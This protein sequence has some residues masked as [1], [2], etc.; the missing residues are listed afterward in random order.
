MAAKAPLVSCLLVLVFAVILELLFSI[1]VSIKTLAP[2]NFG[3]QKKF[4]LYPEDLMR[5]FSQK[6]FA[7]I[8]LAIIFPVLLAA[9]NQPAQHPLDALKTKEYW[10][11][12]DVL[13]DSG[14]MDANTVTHSVLLHEPA[15]DKVLAWKPGDPIFRE[16]DVILLRKGV[17]IEALVDIA[18]HK[19]ESWK[20]RKDVQAPADMGEFRALDEVIKKDPSVIEA[21][22]KHGITDLAPVVCFTDPFSYFALPELEGHRIMMGS[23]SYTHGVYLG[24]SR[25]IEGLQIKVDATEKK[26]LQVIEEGITPVSQAPVNYQDLETAPRPGTTPISIS[27]PLGPSFHIKGSEVSWQNWRFRFRL[28]PRV[29]AVINLAGIQDGDHFRSVLYEGSMSEL[30]VPY[31]DPA[32]GWANRVFIDAGEFYAIGHILKPLRQDIDCP[33][34]AVYFDSLA[35]EEHGFPVIHSQV[36]CLFESYSG[37]PAWRH[38]EGHQLSG[39]GAR[40][41]VLRTA[42]VIGNYDYVLDWRFERDGNLRVAVGATGI[43]ETKAVKAKNASEGG[44][45]HAMSGAPDEFGHFVAENTV[46]VNHDHFFS[47]RLDVDVD[48]VNNSFMAMR[49]VKRQLNNP[50]RKS[51]WVVEPSIAKTEKD[52]MMDIHLDKPSTW[53]FINPNVKGPLGYPTG[54]ELMP[55]TTAASLLDP[56]DGPQKV[57]SF[58]THQLWVTPYK[59]DE[60]F[61]SGVYPTES[62]GDDT[63]AAWTRANR[64]IENTDIVAWYTLGF[65]HITRAEDWPVMPVMW[66]DFVLRPFDFFPQ[67]P[68]QTLPPTP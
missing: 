7:L 48:G 50:M 19:L 53:H 6:T 9:Q 10:T 13:R 59:Q 22:K 54:Y 21:L 24:W 39:S 51:I 32:I 28:D 27:Q 55:G 4:T 30:Y 18:G 8:L 58:S 34:N 15:K 35:W 64:P 26:V 41:L 14:K 2:V 65:H 60:R 40:V 1:P 42:A 63:L 56:D 37:D 66:H 5:T 43:I 25:D 23:C 52:A 57:G 36:G 3:T 38:Y 67:S 16:A 17:T 68:V 29:G 33:S 61:A 62:K 11:A 49:L 12:Y 20:E 31:M 47:Y 44:G 45:G 46:G